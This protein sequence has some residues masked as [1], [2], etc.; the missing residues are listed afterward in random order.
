MNGSY[1]TV[2]CYS[3]P[4]E[5]ME[6]LRGFNDD[7]DAWNCERLDREIDWYCGEHPWDDEVPCSKGDRT[8]NPCCPKGPERPQMINGMAAHPTADSSL[9]DWYQNSDPYYQ[10]STYQD[11]QPGTSKNPFYQNQ[12]E[13]GWNRCDPVRCR[14][15]MDEENNPG[16]PHPAGSKPWNIVATWAGSHDI[17]L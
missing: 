7:G 16:S 5:H 3:Y 2:G 10:N 4:E 11:L 15:A 14:K 17:L 12:Q 1:C 6:Q 9:D 13:F 8:G